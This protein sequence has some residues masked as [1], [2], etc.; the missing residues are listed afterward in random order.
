MKMT[1]LL[2]KLCDGLMGSEIHQNPYIKILH[3]ETFLV[4]DCLWTYSHKKH[5]SWSYSS[6]NLHFDGPDSNLEVMHNTLDAYKHHAFIQ[7]IMCTNNVY[8][9]FTAWLLRRLFS[10]LC[11]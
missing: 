10:L 6:D 1:K 8:K 3:F 7:E 2:W 4:L 5:P 9:Y 11:V